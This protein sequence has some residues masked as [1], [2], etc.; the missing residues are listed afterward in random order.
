MGTG[1]F[2]SFE[3]VDGAGKTT[4]ITRF[5]HWLEERGED[6]L[7]T[8]EPGGDTPAEAIREVIL[9]PAYTEMEPLT[10]AYLY[11]AAR[12]QHVRRVIRPALEA[13]KTVICD[14]YLDSSLAYQGGG[15][16]LGMER[17]RELNREAVDGCF[18]DWTVLLLLTPEA[19]MA[20]MEGRP[21]DRLEQ[22]SVA[23]RRTVYDSFVSLA[24]AEPERIL[25][26]DAARSVQE[27]AGD[28][29]SAYLARFGSY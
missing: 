12:S 14:R 15:R 9:N 27:I 5:A 7:L 24:A 22:T 26:V 21:L 23:F 16:A 28:I 19:A 8:R 6:V 2:I 25:R 17:V 13:G 4:Q 29:R 20:R 3:G 1:R 11:A 10:E 18:P